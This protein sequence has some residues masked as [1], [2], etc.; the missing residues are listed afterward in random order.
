MADK[1]KGKPGREEREEDALQIAGEEGTEKKRRPWFTRRRWVVISACALGGILLLL[2]LGMAIL[3]LVNTPEKL[4]SRLLPKLEEM[5]DGEVTFEDIH[6]SLFP[7]QEVV[8][9]G[10]ALTPADGSAPAVAEELQLGLHLLPL[11]VGD[12]SIS[13]I[14]LLSADLPLYREGGSL[15]LAHCFPKEGSLTRMSYKGRIELDGSRI[16]LLDQSGWSFTW[17]GSDFFCDLNLNPNGDSVFKVKLSWERLVISDTKT[18]E[19]SP[20]AGFSGSIKLVGKHKRKEG[21]MEFTQVDL[22]LAG[23]EL[24]ARGEVRDLG[25]D[26][27]TLDFEVSGSDVDAG[28]LFALFNPRR[29]EVLGRVELVGRADVDLRVS[30]ELPS[31]EGFENINLAGVVKLYDAQITSRS[32]SGGRGSAEDLEAKLVFEEGKV[33]VKELYCRMAGEECV[34]YL[35]LSW[36]GEPRVVGKFWG[37]FD[38]GLLSSLAGGKPGWQV[39]GKACGEIYLDGGV[40]GAGDISYTGHLAEMSGQFYL[41]PFSAPIVVKGGRL[42][43]AGYEMRLM[44]CSLTLGESPITL[45]GTL[46]GFEFPRISYALYSPSLDLDAVLKEDLSP[47]SGDVEALEEGRVTLEGEYTIDKLLLWNIPVEGF[48]ATTTYNGGI[49][50]LNSMEFIAY[51][52]P[53]RGKATIQIRERAYTFQLEGDYVGISN[54]L[55]EFTENYK[56]VLA[57][58]RLS[59]DMFFSA[60]GTSADPVKESITGQGVLIFERGTVTNLS[61]LDQLAE[62]SGVGILNGF[63]IDRLKG[64]FRLGEGG[65]TIR[66]GALSGPE[67]Y[68][69]MIDG[70]LGFDGEVAFSVILRLSP[71]MT[72]K[73]Y[74][75][76]VSLALDSKG[77]GGMAFL[78]SGTLDEPRFKLDAEATARLATESVGEVGAEGLSRF[79]KDE[80]L[81]GLDSE[82]IF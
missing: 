71:Q 58:G 36:G 70:Y 33:S 78:V 35:E 31:G 73:Y 61:I 59:V 10:F 51:G 80:E 76:A 41:S 81:M 26:L 50:Q 43:M 14:T 6:M 47:P 44:D 8:M 66:E 15:S 79:E 32:D 24:S 9:E 22:N 39:S 48:K 30:A 46:K 42:E 64:R 49:L 55:D 17:E 21:H 12:L 28:S 72:R 69:A 23:A 3:L 2:I 27:V 57:G 7:R 45:N 37:E 13:R 25:T 63:F 68:E 65:I 16:R 75:T 38:A 67:I 1:D 82:S 77:R 4:K 60:R 20:F 54:W 34:G 11:I 56:E 62:W 52:G 74:S 19:P 29:Y 53:V 5:V 40:E 18:K